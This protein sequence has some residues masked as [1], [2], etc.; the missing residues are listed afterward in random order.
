M[1]HQSL[2]IARPR[3]AGGVSKTAVLDDLVSTK[4]RYRGIR[5]FG[6]DGVVGDLNGGGP[7]PRDAAEEILDPPV[8]RRQ[9]GA[10]YTAS[11]ARGEFSNAW[12]DVG[13]GRGRTSRGGNRRFPHGPPS[14]VRQTR[15]RAA[16][17]RRARPGCAETTTNDGG[18]SA[19]DGR[20]YH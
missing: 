19:A 14:L 9:A 3:D 17:L 5:G 20:S 15:L 6:V 11:V 1:L 16:S 8:A 10:A 18:A 7:V 13:S 2:D 4:A 12:I